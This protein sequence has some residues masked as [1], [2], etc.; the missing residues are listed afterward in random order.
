MSKKVQKSS[1]KAD[2]SVRHARP[3]RPPHDGT[4]YRLLNLPKI[5]ECLRPAFDPEISAEFDALR[6]AFRWLVVSA[7]ERNFLWEECS[8]LIDKAMEVN[9]LLTRIALSQH[10]ASVLQKAGQPT[11]NMDAGI[12]KMTEKVQA[13]RRWGLSHLD[14]IQGMPMPGMPR[15]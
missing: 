11:P 3:A 14:R 8:N 4:E 13:A 9:D 5:E 2:V 7:Y 1:I 6:A 15:H 12:A 10:F